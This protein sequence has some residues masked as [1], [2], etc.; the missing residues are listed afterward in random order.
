MKLRCVELTHSYAQAQALN[1]VFGNKPVFLQIG[2]APA[3]SQDLA[4]DVH[5]HYAFL[6]KG[7]ECE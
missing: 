1:G 7:V 6:F 2:L 5:S 3:E 4:T